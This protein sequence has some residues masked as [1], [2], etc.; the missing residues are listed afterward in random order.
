MCF[1]LVFVRLFSRRCFEEFVLTLF[2][3]GGPSETTW[4]ACGVCA[5]VCVRVELCVRAWMRACVCVCVRASR[6]DDN[7]LAAVGR[8]RYNSCRPFHLSSTPHCCQV[9]WFFHLHRTKTH[10]SHKCYEAYFFPN[11]VLWKRLVV[12]GTLGRP[13]PWAHPAHRALRIDGPCLTPT[14]TG[15]GCIRTCP[16]EVVKLPIGPCSGHQEQC[17]WRSCTA[18]LPAS[19]PD[20]DEHLHLVI[21]EVGEVFSR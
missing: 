16:P 4:H 13:F 15:A 17:R 7:D 2:P 3:R 5:C 19:T 1:L 21:N 14:L 10:V 12:S 8:H 6:C 11:Q 9:L 20:G 18:P